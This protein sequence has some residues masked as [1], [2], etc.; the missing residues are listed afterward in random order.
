[1]SILASLA[2]RLPATALV[3]VRDPDSG[4]VKTRLAARVGGPAAVRVYRALA[5]TVWEGLADPGLE[6][7]LLVAPP[8]GCPAVQEWLPGAARVLG[9]PE[10]DLG[11]RLAWAFEQAFQCGAP[12]ALAVGTDA[13]EVGAARARE[14]LA[15]LQGA[16][17]IV[18]P[19][20]DGGYALLALKR[21]HPR[22]FEGIPWSTPQVLEATRRQ[23]RT[24]GLD[25]RE[26]EAVRDLDTWDDLEQLRR[27]G[28]WN[29]P[30]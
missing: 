18:I 6:R 5:A 15:A 24:C 29:A 19:A 10:G 22:L 23:A 16:D 28:I 14:A 7:W 3:F 25:L 11:F 21:P 26:L 17:A 27:S 2:A 30:L 13:P 20:L 12:A 8:E 1:V 4:P 9:Q